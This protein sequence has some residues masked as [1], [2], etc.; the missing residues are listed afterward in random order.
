ME[1]DKISSIKVNCFWILSF[2]KIYNLYLRNLERFIYTG[3]RLAGSYRLVSFSFIIFRFHALRLG[4]KL[5][6]VSEGRNASAIKI[7]LRQ[8]Q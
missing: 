7:V 2:I 6:F 4:L 8:S 5:D 1:A 3:L